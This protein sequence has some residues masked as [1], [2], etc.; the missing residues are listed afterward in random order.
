MRISINRS[1]YVSIFIALVI[2]GRV[3]AQQQPRS[4]GGSR[5]ITGRLINYDGQ[6]LAGRKVFIEKLG[7]GS[8]EFREAS[9]NDAGEFRFDSLSPGVYTLF[10]GDQQKLYRPGDSATIRVKKGGVITGIVTDS[11]GEPMIAA[12]VRTLRVRDEN[13]RRVYHT[14]RS[15]PWQRELLTDDRGVY[16]FWGLTSGSY[17]V[18]VG[19][20]S[21]ENGNRIPGVTDDD[22][23]TYHPSAATVEAATEVT[24]RD[25]QEAT[26]VDIRHRGES[27]YAIS[28]NVSGLVASGSKE[29]GVIVTLTHAA[30]G[31]PAGEKV[32]RAADGPSSFAFE[33]LA[34]GEYD[35]T[36]Q[37]FTFPNVNAVSV[38]I[39]AASPHRRVIV[40]GKDV[41]GVELKLAPLGSI[42]GRIV[43]EAGP[44]PRCQT[45]PSP[46]LDET[47]IIFSSQGD[48]PPLPSFSSLTWNVR[49]VIGVPDQR[50]DFTIRSLKAGHYR[51]ETQP[52]GEDWYIRSIGLPGPTQARPLDA[53]RDGVAVRSGQRVTGLTISIQE[54]AAS[55]RG[56]VVLG[57]V[58]VTLPARLFVHLVPAERQQSDDVLRFAE[59]E[60]QSDGSF[61]LTN[62]APGRYWLLARPADD[63]RDDS[64]RPLA[65]DREFR[66]KLTR[67][68]ADANNSIELQPCQRTLN[69]MLRYAPRATTDPK[70]M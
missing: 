57:Q 40:K 26:G 6:P 8:R 17:M 67:E 51:V 33:G 43:V 23:P 66:A 64:T 5:E 20:R 69:H 34:D 31:A 49:G 13:G 1:V 12:R 62:I 4:G 18:S 54:G 44:K 58:N 19:G 10:D 27:G 59:A 30:T 52:P 65:W 37:H 16:R 25:G 22:A 29:E 11:T 68:A 24:V 45:G 47:V 55:L 32:F 28:G 7:G 21:R 61:L 9:T 39:N 3:T 70:K 38:D 2:A 46:H 60:V 36:A 63:L 15:G 35:L 42:D 14:G 41:A 53:G 48:E 56:R 50:G